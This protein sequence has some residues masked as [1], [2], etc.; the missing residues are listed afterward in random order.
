[1]LFSTL[2]NT[3][4]VDSTPL[5]FCS[6]YDLVS[7]YEIGNV[8][9]KKDSI[10]CDI[11][12]HNY[13]LNGFK[14]LE[15]VLIWNYLYQRM[16]DNESNY[17]EFSWNDMC[18]DIGIKMDESNYDVVMQPLLRSF[19]SEQIRRMTLRCYRT[20]NALS[21]RIYA[22]GELRFALTLSSGFCSI[23]PDFQQAVFRVL[24]ENCPKSYTTDV[25]TLRKI[26]RTKY[27]LKGQNRMYDVQFDLNVATA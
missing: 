5:D 14:Y 24:I 18:R 20:F 26:G 16:I 1:M 7:S 2:S 3:S 17:H 23:E 22:D 27:R 9:V 13:L 11:N 10:R 4:G 12:G 25:E 6:R 19:V 21:Q 15:S 8:Q